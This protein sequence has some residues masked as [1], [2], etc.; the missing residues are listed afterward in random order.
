MTNSPHLRPAFIL[1][2]VVKRLAKDIGEGVWVEKG[3]PQREISSVEHIEVCK[4]LLINV[5]LP[6]VNIPELFFP[7]VDET[8]AK[9]EEKLRN[10]NLSDT[11][12]SNTSSGNLLK[13][14]QDTEFRRNMSTVDI[15]A[16]LDR[17]KDKLKDNTDNED[18]KIARCV[19]EF[20]EE[21]QCLGINELL[22]LQ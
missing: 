1:D 15:E 12:A 18:E 3:I 5:Y 20:K 8:V 10:S 19:M 17:Y 6:K 16:A 22:Y 2:R 11:P 4:D 9:F 7:N 13:I 14:I 21:L